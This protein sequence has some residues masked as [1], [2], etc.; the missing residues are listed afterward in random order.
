MFIVFMRQESYTETR[1]DRNRLFVYSE[2]VQL[3][4]CLLFCVITF[5][6]LV[7]H[8]KWKKT[9]RSR[10]KNELKEAP[11]MPRRIFSRKTKFL[12]D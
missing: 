12:S 11:W 9:Q 1:G 8:F 4:F 5:F 7:T 6:L 10:K 2:T 3:F